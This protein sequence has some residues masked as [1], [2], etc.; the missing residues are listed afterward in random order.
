MSVSIQNLVMADSFLYR[1]YCLL[2][3]ISTDKNLEIGISKQ[4]VI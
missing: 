3:L 4:E 2:L 1:K